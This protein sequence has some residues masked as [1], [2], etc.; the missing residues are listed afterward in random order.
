[1][2]FSEREAFCSNTSIHCAKW[3]ECCFTFYMLSFQRKSLSLES[4]LSYLQA[5]NRNSH[6]FPWKRSS[7]LQHFNSLCDVNGVLLHV[8]NAVVSEKITFLSKCLKLIISIHRKLTCSSLIENQSVPTL[9]FTV[10]SEWSVASL[11]KCSSFRENHFPM[12]APKA[13]Y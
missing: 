9:Q 7:L 8:W 2:R 13:T 3:M 10:W 6:V 5:F 12:K 11:F 1:M 4:T